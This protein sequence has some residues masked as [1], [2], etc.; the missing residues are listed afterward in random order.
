ME[1][2][3]NRNGY[4]IR[5]DAGEEIVESLARF[6]AGEGVRAESISGIGAASDPELGY[7]V[8]ES[9]EYVR[10]VFRATGS[11]GPRGPR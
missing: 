5:I 4:V 3:R 8:R 11:W 7:F 1:Q 9:R 2:Q 10:R 6:A